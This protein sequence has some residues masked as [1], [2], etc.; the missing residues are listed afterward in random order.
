MQEFWAL[1][2][3]QRGGEEGVWL[4]SCQTLKGGGV[5]CQNIRW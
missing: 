4:A 5:T 2:S 1:S 3:L